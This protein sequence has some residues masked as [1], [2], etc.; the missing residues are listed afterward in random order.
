MDSILND[1]S[2]IIE[3]IWVVSLSGVLLYNQKLSTGL[4]YEPTLVASL[5]M[6]LEHISHCIQNADIKEVETNKYRFVLLKYPS[7]DI[8]IIAFTNIFTP[9]FRV[10]TLLNI[11]KFRFINKFHKN[12]QKFYETGEVSIFWDAS[13]I[14]DLMQNNNWFQNI[15]SCVL[16]TS[17]IA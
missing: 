14:L 2:P 15:P 9:R 11:F 4:N 1:L 3:E 12:L 16:S 13:K 10:I 5:F 17:I 6:G 7:Y 8:Y